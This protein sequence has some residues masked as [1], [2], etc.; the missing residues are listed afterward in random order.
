MPA[1][2]SDHDIYTRSAPAKPSPVAL[3]AADVETLPEPRSAFQRELVLR[4]AASWVAANL[5][6]LRNLPPNWDS[7]GALPLDRRASDTAE[8]LVTQLLMQGVLPP[9]FFP[10]PEGGISVEWHEDSVEFSID[11]PPGARDVHGASVYFVDEPGGIEWDEPY[12]DVVG[13]VEEI[14]GRFLDRPDR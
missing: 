3:T 4:L 2:L 6:P 11:I 1:V 10:T 13:R 7:Y 14:L 5:E 9:Q 12:G 8:R